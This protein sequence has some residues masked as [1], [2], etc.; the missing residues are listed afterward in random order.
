M[1]K[2]SRAAELHWVCLERAESGDNPH[3]PWVKDR[4]LCVPRRQF[5]T[6]NKNK[7]CSPA[8]PAEPLNGHFGIYSPPTRAAHELLHPRHTEGLDLHLSAPNLTPPPGKKHLRNVFQ[9]GFN[10][11]LSQLRHILGEYGTWMKNNCYQKSYAID[12]EHF[13]ASI[14]HEIFF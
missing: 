13:T 4:A 7:I 12:E 5:S 8:T 9:E 10:S 1:S 2:Q 14:E 11:N 3:T 6:T